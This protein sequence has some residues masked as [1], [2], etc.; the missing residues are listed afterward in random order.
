MLKILIEQR[1]YWAKQTKTT[2]NR[3]A[4]RAA[5]Q[6]L[7]TTNALMIKFNRLPKSDRQA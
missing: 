5:Y 1:D 4:L 2:N 7:Q 3:L 6:G